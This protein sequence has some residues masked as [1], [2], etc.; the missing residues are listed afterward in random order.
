MS[1]CK[2]QRQN[3]LR[4]WVSGLE[5]KLPLVV[6]V[7]EGAADKGVA[8]E[9]GFQGG[10]TEGPSGYLVC[11]TQQAPLSPLYLSIPCPPKTLGVEEGQGVAQI[12]FLSPM[13]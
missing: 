5:T 2:S 13:T 8:V 4:L 7:R 12:P 3:G 9:G 1:D 6:G 11:S 10:R